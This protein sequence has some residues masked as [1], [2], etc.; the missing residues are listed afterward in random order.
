MQEL[1]VNAKTCQIRVNWD[2]SFSVG[3]FHRRAL[4]P[5]A[6]RAR[7]TLRHRNSR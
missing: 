1:F 5:V 2:G 7:G 6:K 3:Q 4:P